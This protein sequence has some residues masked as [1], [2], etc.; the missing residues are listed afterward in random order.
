MQFLKDA[1]IFI[2]I[3]DTFKY[4]SVSEY[5]YFDDGEF[6][7]WFAEKVIMYEVQKP[8]LLNAIVEFKEN[9]QLYDKIVE[10]HPEWLI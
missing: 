4:V 5:D 7:L 10:H 8:F 6:S 3:N 1:V 9:K 2:C